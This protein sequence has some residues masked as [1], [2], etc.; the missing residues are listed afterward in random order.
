MKGNLTEEQGCASRLDGRRATRRAMARGPDP[1]AD[2]VH[3]LRA[4]R[5]L[6]TLDWGVR[7]VADPPDREPRPQGRENGQF[8][9]KWR[10]DE[11]RRPV[12]LSSVSAQVR[13]MR[14]KRWQRVLRGSP[15][16]RVREEHS[17]HAPAAEF[18]LNAVGVTQR[19]LQ[20]GLEV[21]HA[22]ARGRET[23]PS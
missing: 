9:R 1:T 15:D 8:D 22:E 6:E 13:E 18:P 5:S 23:H 14:A 2:L 3:D 16:Y 17:A 12:G 21:D 20:A 11:H 19:G 7:R 4:G 10:P